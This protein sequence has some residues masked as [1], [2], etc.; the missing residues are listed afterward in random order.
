MTIDLTNIELETLE[1][2]ISIPAEQWEGRCYEISCAIVNSGVLG[3]K[4]V[5]VYG[6]YRG[7][8]A[9]NT[10]FSKYPVVRHGWIVLSD[11]DVIIDPTR[12]VFSGEEPWLYLTKTRN[13]DYDR[14]GETFRR[15]M[16]A[17]GFHPQPEFDPSDK[18]L[19]IENPSDAAVLETL[20][21]CTEPRTTVSMNEAF[22]LANRSLDRLGDLALPLYNWLDAKGW[23][24]FIPKDYQELLMDN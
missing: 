21:G 5:A 13:P 19:S 20:L 9:P 1:S 14:G 3:D 18:Q 8:V 16:E 11:C 17:S 15:N 6:H 12:W 7:E 24:A 22:W 4:A 2:A 10:L 23:K